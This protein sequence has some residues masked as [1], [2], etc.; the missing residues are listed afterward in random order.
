MKVS[1][2]Q[3]SATLLIFSLFSLSSS[4]VITEFADQCTICIAMGF[5]YDTIYGDCYTVEDR[6]SVYAKEASTS[7]YDACYDSF[8]SDPFCNLYFNIDYTIYEN[9]TA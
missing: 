2:F 3:A 9:S 7:L 8:S 4:Y 5:K 1:M 6:T